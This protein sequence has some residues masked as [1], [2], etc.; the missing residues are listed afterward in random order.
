MLFVVSTC[1]SQECAEDGTVLV[2]LGNKVDLTENGDNDRRVVDYDTGDK[3]S[4]V[5]CQLLTVDAAVLKATV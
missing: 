3:L 2:L 5:C 4:L 1:L